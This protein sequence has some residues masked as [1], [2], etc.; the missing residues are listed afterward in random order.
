LSILAKCEPPAREPTGKN[1][2]TEW[3]RKYRDPEEDTLVAVGK[4]NDCSKVPPNNGL[5]CKGKRVEKRR[6]R[7]G[8]RVLG[9]KKKWGGKAKVLANVETERRVKWIKNLTGGKQLSGWAFVPHQ[10]YTSERGQN[11]NFP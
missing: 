4:K 2:T 7:R 8:V 11:V 9:R 3:K 6:T 5:I 10:R 1:E